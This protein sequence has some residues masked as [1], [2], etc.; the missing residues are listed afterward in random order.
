M[1]RNDM[2]ERKYALTC[3]EIFTLKD[4][5][6][7]ALDWAQVREETPEDAPILLIMPGITG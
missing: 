2:H 5:G 6:E 3:R 7:V 4:G 1:F